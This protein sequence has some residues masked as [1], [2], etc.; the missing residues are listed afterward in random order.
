MEAIIEFILELF[1]EGSI[2]AAQS[3]RVP[4]AVRYILAVILALFFIA[5]IG[6]I[7]LTGILA[8]RESIL[9]GAFVLTLGVFMLVRGIL[10]FRRIYI[11][12]FRGQ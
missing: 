10:M 11:K 6:I 12:N 2:E 9:L 1:V 3:S 7:F 5:V 8:I 4:A